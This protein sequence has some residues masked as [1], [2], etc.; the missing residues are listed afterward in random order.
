MDQDRYQKGLEGKKFF[1]Q[2][3]NHPCD[4]VAIENPISLVE[5]HGAI[6]KRI[7]SNRSKRLDNDSPIGSGKSIET[8]SID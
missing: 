4:K 1:M 3:Y 5:D 6:N 8:H 7:L 2:F